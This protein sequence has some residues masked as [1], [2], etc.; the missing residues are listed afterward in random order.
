MEENTKRLNDIYDWLLYKHKINGQDDFAKALGTSRPNVTAMLNGRVKVTDDTLRKVNDAFP[1]CFN[2][3]W[4]L[5]GEP[6]ML[7]EDME[8]NRK[9]SDI[10]D[11]VQKLIDMATRLISQNEILARKLEDDIALNRDLRE[12]LSS[13]LTIYGM[14]KPLH[15][16]EPMATNEDKS[17]NTRV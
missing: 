6:P 15:P 11:Y 4:M 16:D 1:G 5:T 17:Q 3:M 12:Q 2:I 13:L 7:I 10:P 14:H 9:S 8:E